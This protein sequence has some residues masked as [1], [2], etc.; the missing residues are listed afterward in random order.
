MAKRQ[1]VTPLELVERIPDF[2]GREVIAVGVE[3]PGISGGLNDALTVEPTVLH[4]GDPVAVVTI[5]RVKTVDHEPFDKKDLDG[6]LRRVQVVAVD[7]AHVI[8]DVASLDALLAGQ[9]AAIDAAIIA[10][11]ESEGIHRLPMNADEDDED[12][13]EATVMARQHNQGVHADGLRPECQ[14]CTLEAEFAAEENG[15][16]IEEE[17]ARRPV[18]AS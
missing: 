16:S 3:V 7:E 10:S 8:R 9:R 15:T 2:E 14:L 4:I 18:P 6:S 1:L 17:L 11:E 12:D 5:G 13:D